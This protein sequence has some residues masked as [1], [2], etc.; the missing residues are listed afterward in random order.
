MLDAFALETP[1]W[2][3]LARGTLVYLALAVVLRVMPKRQSGNLSPNDMIA[4]IV[5]G[6]VAADGMVGDATSATDLFVI[7]L[8]V[9]LCDY[10][11]NLAEYYFPR[12]RGINQHEP[13]L[14]IHNGILIKKNLG[15]E[16]LTEQ[17]LKASLRQRGIADVA[18]VKQAIL[19]TD[20]Q[21]S[22]IEKP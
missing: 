15:R 17:E 20:G 8:V 6:T 14:L 4:L 16:K 11:F 12:L 21:I 19:E 1:L 7:V 18:Q 9:L 10:L 5:V 13:T 3:L 2:E 22:V